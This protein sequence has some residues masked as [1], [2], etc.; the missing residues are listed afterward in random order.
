MSSEDLK[1]WKSERRS[2]QELE[3]ETARADQI[4]A[5][6]TGPS[7]SDQVANSGRLRST[8]WLPRLRLATLG[9]LQIRTARSL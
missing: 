3:K 5:P 7:C 2:S 4:M 6:S 8:G 1:R 9:M